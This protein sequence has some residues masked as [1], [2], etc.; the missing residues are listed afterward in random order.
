LDLTDG[1]A[2]RGVFDLRAALLFLVTAIYAV[3]SLAFVSRVEHAYFSLLVLRYI[4]LLPAFLYFI[5]SGSFGDAPTGIPPIPIKW[6][7]GLF[8]AMAAVTSWYV[9]Q[10]IIV[11]DESS[12]R[13][14]GLVFASGRLWAD[15]PPG[16][17]T[18]ISEIPPP[19]YFEHLIVSGQKWYG[20]IPPLWP[21]VLAPALKLHA[22]WL[23]SPIFGALLLA[24]AAATARSIFGDATTGPAAALMMA[25][26]PYYLTN[27]V[28]IMTHAFCGVLIATAIW[29]CFRGLRSRRLMHFTWMFALLSVAC[30][31]RYYTG[32]VMAATL[33]LVTL[34]NLRRDLALLVRT[35]V[36]GILF[37]MMILSAILVYNQTYTGNYLVSPYAVV[38]DSR[39]PFYRSPQLV[40]NP[41]AIWASMLHDKRWG[42]QRTLFYTTPFLLLLAGYGVLRE[43]KFQTEVRILALLS[44]CLVVTYQIVVE[45]SAAINGERYY[46]EVFSAVAILAARGLALLVQNAGIPARRLATGLAALAALQI[47]LQGLAIDGL[48]SRTAGERQLREVAGRLTGTRR[49]AFLGD[50]LPFLPK[51]FLMN[52][53]DWRSADLMFL[54]DPGPAGRQEWACRMDRPQ[55]VVFGYD[56]S[57]RSITQEFGSAGPG[58]CHKL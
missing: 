3:L 17:G 33:G 35:A 43:R 56:A 38:F 36:V 29:L 49:T 15:A 34:W 7:V 31:T 55:W 32:A 6:I 16:A 23:M 54:V 10:G 48:V 46:F 8:L 44:V 11:P 42:A 14:Q 58:R 2:S 25:L 51:H 26:S 47:C 9:T 30:L 27:S 20:Q 18:R 13:F 22:E 5:R 50:T 21:A 40:L 24:I 57:S 41:H 53:P 12:Y 1:K 37:A 19:L 52:G 4:L 28:G 45:D 39:D